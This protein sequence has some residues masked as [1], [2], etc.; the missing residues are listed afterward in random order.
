MRIQLSVSRREE[1]A[2]A[3]MVAIFA[4]VLIVLAGFTT[5]FGMAYAQRQALATGADSAAL[6]VVH[7][8]Y[9][10]EMADPTHP[11]CD[12]LV[13]NDTA[14]AASNTKKASTIALAQVNANAPFNATIAAADVTTILVCVPPS[15]LAGTTSKVLKVSVK[16][17]RTI[18]PILGTVLGASPMQINRSAV[19]AL[20][21]G[22]SV[23]GLAP[24]GLCFNQA[25]AIINQHNADLI[26]STPDR[27]QLVSPDKVWGAGSQCDGGGAG[28]WGWLTFPGQGN[29]SGDLGDMIAAGYPGAITLAATTP[30]SVALDGVPGNRG[31]NAHTHDAMQT[32]M[33]TTQT[34]PVYNTITGN[35]ANTSFNVIGFLSVK[36]CG[37]DVTIRD[38][39]CYDP[40]VP[41]TNDSMQVRYVDY[42]PAAQ[43]STRCDIGADCAFNAYVTKLLANP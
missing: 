43:L 6:A 29:G 13:T 37:Y 27:A 32:I 18:M 5:D 7:A 14:L 30:P 40:T 17:N 16:V 24:I 41:M 21:V 10:A 20:G 22:N 31:A 36:M 34:F 42:T 19:A 2:V 25:L 8:K 11:T 38:A 1:G 9:I 39:S 4:V 33:G 35:G 28:N 15:A 12:Q 23:V 3:V 26:T